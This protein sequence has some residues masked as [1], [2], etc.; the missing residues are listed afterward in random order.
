M[1]ER[2]LNLSII[3]EGLG[4]AV[5][6]GSFV[7]SP[8]LR[9]WHCKWDATDAEVNKSLPGDDLVLKPWLES[10]RAITIQDGMMPVAISPKSTDILRYPHA[11]NTGSLIPQLV[12][13][14]AVG[15]RAVKKYASSHPPAAGSPHPPPLQTASHRGEHTNRPAP[16]ARSDVYL[17]PP[18]APH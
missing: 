3:E 4:A 11:L 8:V 10:T 17:A 12:P 6:A 5:I 18:N 14:L 15:L 1:P 9:P 2:R 7:L 13:I 16:Q